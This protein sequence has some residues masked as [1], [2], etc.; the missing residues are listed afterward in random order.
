MLNDSFNT[1]IE[2]TDMKKIFLTIIL[3]A[4]FV[5]SF[6]SCK[7]SE[8]ERIYPDPSKTSTA[9]IENF[10]TGVFQS[11]NEYTMPWY[12]KLFV[13]ENSTMGHY[14][15]VYGWLNANDQ[16]LPSSAAQED[17]WKAYFSGV[18]WQYREMQRL[19]NKATPEEQ[20]DKRIFMIAA[21]IFFYDQSEQI[22]DTW[23]DIPWSKAG[24]L[25]TNDGDL[26]ASLPSY[27]KAEDIYTAMLDD[28]KS[29]ATE[30]NTIQVAGV[31]Q[32][33][34]A[35][36]DYINGGDI[37]TWKK[38][39]NS[40]RLRML[41]RVSGAS[42]FS[43][44]ATSEISE[45][46]GNPSTYPVVENNAENIDLDCKGPDLTSNK[47]Q[48]IQNGLETWGTQ[49]YA[50]KAMCDFMN[51]NNDP[52]LPVFFDPNKNGEYLG[53]DPMANSA[54]QEAFVN[55]ALVARYDSATFSRND[56]VPGLLITAAEISFIKAEAFSKGWA[57]GDAKVAYEA[58]VTQSIQL[59]YYI[60]SM[61]SFRDPLTAPSAAEILAYLQ[62]AGVSWSANTDKM[63][64][65]GTQKWI[66]FN[67]L[68]MPQG[69][70]EVRRLKKPVL[71]FLLDSS[72]P[73]TLPPTR[74][75]YVTGEKTLNG[76]N[77][78]TVAAKDTYTTKIFW[79]VN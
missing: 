67:I 37:T 7:K 33:I 40:L 4:A 73:L 39:C 6:N 3:L 61:G 9:S 68:Q 59:F 46:L 74:F 38:Y 48:N 17:R 8:M 79:D 56:N 29:I 43:S 27:D 70:A 34:F 49:N 14:S 5:V 28:L 22:V 75:T 47:D 71:N 24:M 60:N 72:S 19:Y 63:N 50:P 69:W 11:A 15:Q 12:W 55:N 78:A 30:L 65:I 18:M 13:V 57:T 35:N 31:Y 54:T 66:N 42:A 58:G 77:Y 53:I 25:K 41:T 2:R 20:A 10:M 64:L 62:K 21:T 26:T 32:G 23:S 16:Y 51:S 36:K 1:Q 52:R 76:A 45:I 44:R